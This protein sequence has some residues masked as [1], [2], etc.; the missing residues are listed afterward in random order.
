MTRLNLVGLG[1][2]GNLIDLVGW[3]VALGDEGDPG[4]PQWFWVGYLIRKRVMAY[5]RA[6]ASADCPTVIP[7]NHS[8]RVEGCR[9]SFRLSPR[10][11]SIAS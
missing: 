10:V 4:R 7:A 1:D 8:A 6:I 9:M 2:L 11:H 5:R 3:S